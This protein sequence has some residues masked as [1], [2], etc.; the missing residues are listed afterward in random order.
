MYIYIWCG[1]GKG[2]TSC[3]DT[4]LPLPWCGK[5]AGVV[6]RRCV[7]NVYVCPYMENARTVLS[8]IKEIIMK[9]NQIDERTIYFTQ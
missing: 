8:Q 2:S 6:S 3:L 7:S 1:E 9:N 4:A 5:T